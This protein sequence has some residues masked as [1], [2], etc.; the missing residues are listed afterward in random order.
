MLVKKNIIMQYYYDTVH[1][2]CT[3]RAMLNTAVPV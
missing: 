1:Q 2:S 3:C